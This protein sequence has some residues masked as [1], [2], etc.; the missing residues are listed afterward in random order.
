ML[1]LDGAKHGM[2]HL[3]FYWGG[4]EGA[5]CQWHAHFVRSA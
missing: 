1:W 4:W 5:V 3:P 2:R